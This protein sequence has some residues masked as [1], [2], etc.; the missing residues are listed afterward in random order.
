MPGGKETRPR[1][2]A[3]AWSN[4]YWMLGLLFFLGV[5]YGWNRGPSKT[6]SEENRWNPNFR[7]VPHFK[8]FS[9]CVEEVLA[10][11]KNMR[12]FGPAQ[13]LLRATRPEQMKPEFVKWWRSS[14]RLSPPYKR[15]NLK[16]WEVSSHWER[17]ST[18]L[19]LS[20]LWTK[21]SWCFHLFCT[22]HPLWQSQQYTTILGLPNLGR[23]GRHAEAAR[24][25]SKRDEA[26]W[27][28]IWQRVGFTGCFTK[29]P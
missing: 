7:W 9:T 2:I 11:S 15:L 26:D 6:S 10:V 19:G 13:E 21:A 29:N 8:T 22:C 5:V 16:K 23:W 12:F 17:S 3:I 25:T 1:V 27:K 14:S 24:L 28:R 18:L 20:E 4:F